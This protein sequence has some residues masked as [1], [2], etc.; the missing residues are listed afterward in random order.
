[1]AI[2]RESNQWLIVAGTRGFTHCNMVTERWRLFGNESQVISLLIVSLLIYST[3][4]WSF[5]LFCTNLLML[6][7]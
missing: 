7:G 6:L 2:D 5:F 3:Q 1:M 4:F